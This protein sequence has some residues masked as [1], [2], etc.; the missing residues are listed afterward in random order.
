MSTADATPRLAALILCGGRSRRMGRP[1]YLL[2]F[3][4]ELLLPRM[5][6]IAAEAASPVIVVAAPDQRMPD[7]PAGV[8]V[9]RDD[10]IDAGPL[11]G[12]ARG[13]QHLALHHPDVPAAFVTSCDVP[14]LSAD[15]IRCVSRQL[16]DSEAVAVRGAE[17]VHPLCA[18][19]RSCLARPA[20]E[21]LQ[22]GERRPR[23]LLEAVRTQF[24]PAESLRSVDPRLD[25]LHNMNTPADYQQILSRL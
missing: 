21:L 2:E 7:L 25:C 15:V 24:I 19:Y 9:V 23:R 11:A 13:L 8:T 17:F 10:L 4:G 5:C 14:L 12:I 20:E 1:K 3:P 18:V 6:R 22:A 16:G